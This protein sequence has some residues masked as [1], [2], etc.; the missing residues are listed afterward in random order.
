MTDILRQLLTGLRALLVLTVLLGIG[1]PVA[2]WGVGQVAFRSQAEGSLIQ[3]NG[4][5]VG[6]TLIGQNFTGD[7]W[8]LPRPSANDY[9][10]QAS[11]GTNAGP[12]D[13][14]LITSINQ[15]RTAIAKS[16]DVAPEAVPADALTASASGLDPYISPE[17]A[18]IQTARVANTRGLD[19]T[20]VAELVTA[21]TSGRILG[22]LGE[23]RV[24]VLKVNLALDAAR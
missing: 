22:F 8:F 4:T 18:Q 21:N 5:V 9:D 24:N 1:Y 7:Q 17:Y 19:E 23:P 16:N 10:A 6:S 2:V 11:G 15:R 3:R 20:K 14:D 12:S 13:E